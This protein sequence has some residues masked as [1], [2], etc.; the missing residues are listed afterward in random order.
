MTTN[1]SLVD[2]FKLVTSIAFQ[3]SF[4]AKRVVRDFRDFG[5]KLYA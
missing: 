2:L 5:G 1:E 4:D 3:M